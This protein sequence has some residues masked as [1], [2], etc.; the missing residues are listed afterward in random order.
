MFSTI[1][2]GTDGS[3]TAG[4]AVDL[5]IDLAA[6]YGAKLVI[7]SAYEPAP[8]QKRE[9]DKEL[10]EDRQWE[11]SA[12]EEVDATLEEATQRALARGIEPK[13]LAR[14]GTPGKIICELAEELNAD[15]LVVGNKGMDRR[16][17]GSV[18]NTISHNAPCSVVIAKTT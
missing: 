3:K 13:A 15:L 1:A 11:P 6:R 14:E 4:A 12:H 17:L 16:I 10:P 18:P 9:E 8:R 7:L 5:A 2:V